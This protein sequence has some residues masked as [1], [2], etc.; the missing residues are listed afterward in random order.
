[1]ESSNG[2]F[3]GLWNALKDYLRHSSLDIQF[4]PDLPNNYQLENPVDKA[5]LIGRGPSSTPRKAIFGKLKRIPGENRFP[6]IHQ[7]SLG[8]LQHRLDPYE[9]LP[10]VDEDPSCSSTAYPFEEI[11]DGFST[12]LQRPTNYADS[13]IHNSKWQSRGYRHPSLL[14]RI[15]CA[16]PAI[17]GATT[18]ASLCIYFLDSYLSLPRLPS[19]KLPRIGTHYALWPY[20]SCIGAT[21]EELFKAASITTALCIVSAFSIDYYLGKDIVQGIW[22]RRAKTVFGFNTSAFLIALAFASINGTRHPGQPDVHMVC[23]CLCLCRG[24]TLL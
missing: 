7:K 23:S 4:P 24:I 15:I 9:Q 18:W 10:E 12:V 8:P 16:S 13:T 3:A 22:W 2:I 21:K 17:L 5:P 14:V 11:D 20:I 1:M 6:R 19:G